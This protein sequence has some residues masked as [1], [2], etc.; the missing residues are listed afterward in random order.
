[1]LPT[2]IDPDA[3]REP[4]AELR[5]QAVAAGVPPPE[6]AVM[7]SLP[8]GDPA[9]ARDAIAAHRDA[10]ATRLIHGERYADFDAFRRMLDALAVVA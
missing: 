8:L 2:G 6:V 10:G 4:I 1:M 3:L 5:A 9:R 7:T